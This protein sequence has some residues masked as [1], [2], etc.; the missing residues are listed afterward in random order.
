MRT[1]AASLLLAAIAACTPEP[2]PARPDGG[3]LTFLPEKHTDLV[4]T[5]TAERP[6]GGPA[7]ADAG[8]SSAS[9]AAAPLPLLSAEAVL[10][11][12]SAV[13]LSRDGVT[14]IDPQARFRLEV[15]ARLEDTRLSLLDARDAMV[16]GDG[17]TEAGASTRFTLAPA[18]PLRPGSSYTLRLDGNEGRLVRAGDGRAFEPASLAL[19]VSGE[20]PA[21]PPRKARARRPRRR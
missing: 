3:G 12:G 4:F 6:D 11:D 19:R 10:P 15:S 7:D 13:P 1:A 5:V 20:P 14:A 9:A 21:P 18:A 17:T 16:P 8:A 2:P